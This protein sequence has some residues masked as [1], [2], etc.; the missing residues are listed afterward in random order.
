MNTKWKGDL[1]DGSLSET[2]DLVDFDFDG[3][4]EF[5]FRTK[6]MTT[7]RI[8]IPPRRKTFVA[9]IFIFRLK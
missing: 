2:S 7:E 8:P 3:V 6:K 1:I 4:E 9:S 5:F